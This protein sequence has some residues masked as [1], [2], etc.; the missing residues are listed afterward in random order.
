MQAFFLGFPCIS[1]Q[2][3]RALVDSETQSRPFRQ[4]RGRGR[5]RSLAPPLAGVGLAV[6][7]RD[8]P[9][10]QHLKTRA[11]FAP[12]RTLRRAP[13]HIHREETM[14]D[15][16]PNARIGAVLDKLGAA[17]A[18]G[19]IDAA[20]G[21][22]A[23]ESYWRDLV[24]FTWNIKTMEGRDQVRDMLAHCLKQAK[25]RDWRIAEGEVATEADGVLESWIS[26]ETEIARGYGLIRHQGRRDLDLADDD[27]R[28][29]GPRGEG[30]LH[31]PARRKARRQSRRQNLEGIARRG[32]REARL[33]N[34][35]LR[36]D[37]RRRAGRDRTRR[38]PAGN[39]ACRRSSSRR[40]SAPAIPGASATSRSACTIRSGTTICPISTSRRTGR[41]SRPRT[42]SAIGWK[43]T[44]R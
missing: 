14:L 5:D 39:S 9:A 1:L 6:D 29:Q 40:T 42:R 34:A 7:R 21:L 8:I 19:D 23:A 41:C 44:P 17:L 20:V 11:S 38:A 24:A 12:S 25:P 3:T 13:V 37:H 16:A 22:F 31:S 43:C 33:R 27:G 18:A 10:C 15:K 26:F 30:G 36:A 2:P 35:A 4:G 28:T 32:G